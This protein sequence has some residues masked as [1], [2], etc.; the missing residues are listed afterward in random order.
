M[1]WEYNSSRKEQAKRELY[2]DMLKW[3]GAH[4]LSALY[5][6]Q[7]IHSLR[8]VFGKYTTSFRSG[9]GFNGTRLTWSTS[10]YNMENFSTMTDTKKRRFETDINR[11]D[12]WD[13]AGKGVPC[14]QSVF[15]RK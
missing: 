11:N 15:L 1:T 3:P 2:T 7:L 6:R 5:G 10:H 9:V 13:F 8:V 14:F 4:R 12:K